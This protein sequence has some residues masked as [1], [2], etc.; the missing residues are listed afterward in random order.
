M[1]RSLSARLVG[2]ALVWL[3]L[4]LGGGGASLSFAFRDT[5]EREFQYRL[6]ALLRALVAAVEVPADGATAVTRPLGE[7]RFEQIYSGWYWQVKDGTRLV[8]SRSLW[9]ATLPVHTDDGAVQTRHAA[10][11]DGR[12]LMVVERD[13]AVPERPEPLH[14]LVAGDLAEVE[15]EVRRFGLLL[16]SSLGLLGAGLLV[17]LVIQVR[18]GL[19]PL[20][21]LASDLDRVRDGGHERL[22]GDYPREVA[23]LVRAMNA[24]LD[25][26]AE[27]IARARTHVGNLAHGLKT[28]L[29]VLKAELQAG[30][31][32]DPAVM[33]E[34]LQQMD[35]L[36]SHHLGRAAAAA[37]SGRVLGTRVVLA[38]VLAE[39]RP[40]LLRLHADK[41]LTMEL[42]VAGDVTMIGEREDVEELLGNLL[43]NACKWASARVRVAAT[44]D[45]AGLRLAVEDD[46]PGL[47]PDAA[48]QVA[49]RGARFDE[50]TP[51]WGLGLAIVADL[52][53]LHGGT[54][55]F[56]RSPMG[57]LRVA[58]FLPG[59]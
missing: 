29:S 35:R 48:D 43:D 6:D 40:V 22:S 56:D 38:E 23:P 15:R 4:L 12:P 46:G 8:R 31:Q 13:I 10:G 39:M 26:D 34:Q 7:P 33:A 3:A 5:V 47:S 49:R 30:A 52:V 16:G 24:V 51:G 21:R 57:G 17:A 2:A 9:D 41:A 44:A 50:Q 27:I 42:D 53:A 19:R 14:V 55:G 28:P 1:P 59:C 37:P 32:A 11:P 20:R 18:F 25:H 45:G 36:I 54:L 58:V